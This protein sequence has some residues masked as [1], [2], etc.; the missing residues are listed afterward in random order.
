MASIALSYNG[1]NTPI[2]AHV[3]DKLE[4]VRTLLKI[5]RQAYRKSYLAPIHMKNWPKVKLG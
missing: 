1:L 3:Y 4:S 5:T 2:I